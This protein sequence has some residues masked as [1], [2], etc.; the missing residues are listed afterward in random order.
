MGLT[1]KL[2]GVTSSIP[3]GSIEYGIS[4]YEDAQVLEESKSKKA[5]VIPLRIASLVPH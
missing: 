3:T 2:C 1:K 4:K 5:K